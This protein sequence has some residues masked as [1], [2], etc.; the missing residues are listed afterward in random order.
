MSSNV[1]VVMG[2]CPRDPVV[3]RIVKF[4]A[5]RNAFFLVVVLV[6]AVVVVLVKQ[7]SCSNAVNASRSTPFPV[8]GP[9]PHT[10]MPESPAPS[11]PY[12]TI[13]PH[14]PTIDPQSD[15][16]TL[17]YTTAYYYRLL[18]ASERGACSCC[19]GDGDR[20]VRAC[21]LPHGM[22]T[23]FRVGRGESDILSRGQSAFVRVCVDA[24][25][26]FAR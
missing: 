11:P 7:C 10:T 6:V 3:C 25:V 15:Y 26:S 24:C 19:A 12:G 22:C 5:G 21:C 13:A 1:Y 18:L 2:A 17:Y 16:P 8:C 20:A 23:S 4:T 14:G 9:G